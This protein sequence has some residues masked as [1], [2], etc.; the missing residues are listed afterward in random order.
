M[1]ASL[2][3]SIVTCSY[4]QGKF[5]DSTIR[6]V[7]EQDYPQL[8]Y[9]VIDGGSSDSTIEIL[10][11]HGSRIDYWVSEP[12][13]GQTDALIKGFQRC[14]GEIMGWLCSDDLLL[15]GA[16]Q[17]V[18][19]YFEEHPEVQAV[20]GDA[21]WIDGHGKLIR[22]KREIPYFQF[23]MR[24]D[25]NYVPQPSMF[26]RRG[27]FERVGG[28]DPR[29]NLA[30]DADLWDRFAQATRIAHVPRFLSCM[31]YYPEQK[32]RRLRAAGFVETDEIALRSTLAR[33][34]PVRVTLHCAARGT[35]L[36]AKLMTGRYVPAVPR[37]IIEALE[38]YRIADDA[39]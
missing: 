30:M 22:Q 5:I 6:S 10:K 37:D 18:A 36:F 9:I 26:W 23:L 28:L 24:F 32:T 16:L 38:R 29:F 35:R 2:P 31:R 25:H 34:A 1:S 7:L 27:L 8:E 12:D 33:L 17:A 21:L 13:N 14:R 4:Q 39:R 11:T 3:I 15:P 20:Y 19:D